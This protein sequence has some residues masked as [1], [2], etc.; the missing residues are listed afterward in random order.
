MTLELP[1]LLDI[2]WS[3]YAERIGNIYD[4]Y[5]NEIYGKLSFFGKPVHCRI[6][7]IYDNKHECFWHLMTQDFEKRKT[8]GERFPDL[9]R[10]RRIHWI[11]KIIT[12][13]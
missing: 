7:P 9:H 10:C 5:L 3:N 6:I 2:D 13:Y 1:K 4:V 12:N 8:N 11:A